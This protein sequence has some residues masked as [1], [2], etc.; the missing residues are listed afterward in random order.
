MHWFWGT[1]G[2][3]R[4]CTRPR[5]LTGCFDSEYYTQGLLFFLLLIASLKCQYL[6]SSHLL[7]SSPG[8]PDPAGVPGSP[9]RI[10][11]PLPLLHCAL[12]FGQSFCSLWV[13]LLTSKSKPLTGFYCPNDLFLI[14][15]C[16]PEALFG[17]SAANFSKPRCHPLC[18]L[19]LCAAV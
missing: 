14:L 3:P 18:R 8:Y 5:V 9:S 10:L 7:T 12:H 19:I 11:R 4:E 16:G 6:L 2:L 1:P 15:Q 17:S 13:Q